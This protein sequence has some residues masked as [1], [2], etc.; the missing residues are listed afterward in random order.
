MAENKLAIFA[1]GSGTNAEEF[2]RYFNQHPS[3]KIVVLLSN[4]PDAYALKRAENHGIPVHVFSGNSFYHSDEIMN[5]LQNNEINH[6]VLAGFMWLVPENIINVYKNRIYNIHP[7]LL[8]KHGG[9]GMYGDRV[10]KAVIENGEI[11]S[12]ISIHYVNNK[13][14]DGN[15]IFQAKCPV[16]KDDTPNSLANRIHQLEYA[17]YPRVVEEVISGKIL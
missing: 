3:I 4:N 11:E 5:F 2:F 12:G 14:D 1:S 10:H 16:L 6:I 9:K 17:H 8:P 7:A 15:I 13:F